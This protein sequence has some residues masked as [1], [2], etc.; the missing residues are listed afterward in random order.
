MIPANNNIA[1]I[2][3]PNNGKSAKLATEATICGR[4]I[5]VLN[6]PR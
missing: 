2:E 4:Q 3:L 5:L 6:K 1:G